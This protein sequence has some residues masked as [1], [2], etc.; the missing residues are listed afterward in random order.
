M[1]LL[2]LT[3]KDLEFLEASNISGFCFEDNRKNALIFTGQ[4][5]SDI[6]LIYLPE[7]SWGT[8]KCYC[9]FCPVIGRLQERI[10]RGTRNNLSKIS[11]KKMII[12][13][14]SV[15]LDGMNHFKKNWNVVFEEK[16]KRQKVFCNMNMQIDKYVGTLN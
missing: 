14:M 6:I 9:H 16:L 10:E 4:M 8:I 3:N 12:T 7:C 11:W 15:A 2:R 13:C 1:I 5:L